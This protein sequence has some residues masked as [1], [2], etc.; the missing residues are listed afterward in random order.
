LTEKFDYSS[1]LDPQLNQF[2]TSNEYPKEV[3]TAPLNLAPIKLPPIIASPI[4]TDVT[5]GQNKGQIVCKQ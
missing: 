2:L 4:V 5:D 1:I 3:K